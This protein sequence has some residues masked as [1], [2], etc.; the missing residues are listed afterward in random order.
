MKEKDLLEDLVKKQETSIMK[1]KDQLNKYNELND[2]KDVRMGEREDQLKK[3]IE[4]LQAD[5][6]VLPNYIVNLGNCCQIV[7]NSKCD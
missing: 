4:K 1:L 3:E 7:V 5:V 2:N 6:S